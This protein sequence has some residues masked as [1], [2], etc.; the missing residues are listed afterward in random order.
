VSTLA[1]PQGHVL[2]S[3]LQWQLPVRI[4]LHIAGCLRTEVKASSSTPLRC[5]TG[6]MQDYVTDLR[7][8]SLDGRNHPALQQQQQQQATSG[9]LLA[10]VQHRLTLGYNP[11]YYCHPRPSAAPFRLHGRFHGAVYRCWRRHGAIC[12]VSPRWHVQVNTTQLQ[13]RRASQLHLWAADYARAGAEPSAAA[14]QVAAVV[15]S[16]HDQYSTCIVVVAI[17]CFCRQRA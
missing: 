3:H 15:Q 6:V 14:V 11:S 12:S 13:R 4:C 8:A 17:C 9:M 5:P 1:I 7:R 10:F 16:G 2:V